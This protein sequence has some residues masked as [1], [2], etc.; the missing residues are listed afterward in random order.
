MIK[1]LDSVCPKCRNPFWIAFDTEGI[2][3]AEFA[4][5][6]VVCDP[7]AR[8]MDEDWQRYRR[9]MYRAYGL[10]RGQAQEELRQAKAG[11]SLPYRDD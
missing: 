11:R 9:Q 7:C 2:F 6:G 5:K 8:A 3:S 10:K 4:R 1:P